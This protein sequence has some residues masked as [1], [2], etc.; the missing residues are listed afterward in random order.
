MQKNKRKIIKV[1]NTSYGVILPIGW[2]RYYELAEEGE[3]E[4][5]SN[6]DVTIKPVG[7]KNGKQTKT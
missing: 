2:V 3:V 6:G 5:I 4:V 1:G 7:E